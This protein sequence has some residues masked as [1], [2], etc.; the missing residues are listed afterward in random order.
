MD[1]CIFFGQVCAPS[2]HAADHILDRLISDPGSIW[3]DASEHVRLYTKK[4]G[5]AA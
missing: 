2:N 1:N 3:K 5:K 4:I